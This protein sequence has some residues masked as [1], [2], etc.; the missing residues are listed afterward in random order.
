MTPPLR[1][2]GPG[3]G[4][5]WENR[6]RAK[7]ADPR[8]NPCANPYSK[9][10][11]TSEGGPVPDEQTAPKDASPCPPVPP[12]C[13][14]Y[15]AHPYVDMAPANHPGAR[16]ANKLRASATFGT[17]LTDCPLLQGTSQPMVERIDDET[18]YP[19]PHENLFR[20]GFGVE[21]DEEGVVS[22]DDFDYSML[23]NQAQGANITKFH[24]FCLELPDAMC[25]YCSITL[26]TEKVCWVGGLE[27]QQG[28]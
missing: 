1:Q 15:D 10:A 26:Y 18:P 27:A 7:A 23:P 16:G 9:T 2:G 6:D 3:T 22:G 20:G 5:L 13:C 4:G 19:W 25:N 17:T 14:L 11:K 8:P 28:G 21:E 24:N 12:D